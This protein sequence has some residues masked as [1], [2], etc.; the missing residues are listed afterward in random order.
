MRLGALLGRNRA[1]SACM[2]LS[3]GL[4]DGAHQLAAASGVGMVIDGSLVPIEPG[5]RTWSEQHG[6]DALFEA[7]T[8]GDDYELMFTCRPRL[9]GRFRTVARQCG[10]ALTRVGECTAGIDVLLYR[11]GRSE[12]MP[13]GYG[14]FR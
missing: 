7:V 3:D 14:H 1:A 4:A 9:G 10:V 6:R 13:R 8:G 2:D 12:P 11:G 5:A